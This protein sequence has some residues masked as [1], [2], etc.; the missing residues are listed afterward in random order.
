MKQII[1]CV[2]SVFSVSSDYFMDGIKMR[3]KRVSNYNEMNDKDALIIELINLGT[4]HELIVNKLMENF[5]MTI[6]EAKN[7]YANLT[8]QPPN[9]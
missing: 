1:G 3:Y 6:D 8:H 7:K 2:S 9:T 4:P 5:D